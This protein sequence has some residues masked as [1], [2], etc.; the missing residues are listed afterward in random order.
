MLCSSY[1][2][3]VISWV[4]VL[5]ILYTY[6][7]WLHFIDLIFLLNFMFLFDF[8]LNDHSV[9]W[10]SFHLTQAVLFSWVSVPGRAFASEF[11]A[12][13]LRPVIEIWRIWRIWKLC[14]ISMPVAILGDTVPSPPSGPWF[15]IVYQMSLVLSLYLDRPVHRGRRQHVL[16]KRKSWPE[17]RRLETPWLGTGMGF[18]R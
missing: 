3:M 12:R 14:Q 4:L 2:G 6:S 18:A 16:K 1:E 9:G 10:G 5:G 15:R 8:F 11:P 17:V 7:F 13:P